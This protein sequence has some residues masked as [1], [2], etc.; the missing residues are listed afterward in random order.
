MKYIEP[1][2]CGTCTY[3]GHF[4]DDDPS[5][6]DRCCFYDR[7]TSCEAICNRWESVYD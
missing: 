6:D 2:C 5:D 4:L 1:R 7:I 3:F